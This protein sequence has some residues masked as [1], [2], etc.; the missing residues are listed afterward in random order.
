MANM[1][2]YPGRAP[3]AEQR[4]RAVPAEHLRTAPL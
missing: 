2:S 3:P 4:V 1:A